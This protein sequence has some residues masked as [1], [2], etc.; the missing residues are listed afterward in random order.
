MYIATA[1]YTSQ[2]CECGKTHRSV[3]GAYKCSRIYSGTKIVSIGLAIGPDGIRRKLQG[4]LTPRDCDQLDDID[5][6]A[7]RA[8]RREWD[9]IGK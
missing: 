4:M 1:T 9:R 3:R 6:E 5:A 8:A 7:G 2:T